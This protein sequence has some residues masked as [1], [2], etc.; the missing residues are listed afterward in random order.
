[1]RL[2]DSPFSKKLSLQIG[3][4]K[5]DFS[6]PKIMGVLNVTPDSFFD[7]GK[8]NSFENAVN[9][10]EK[11]INEGAEF[12]DVGG[13]SSRPGA[14]EVS[15]E[16]E[17]NRTVPVVKA[18]YEKFPAVFISID[19]FRKQVA[20]E[21]IKAGATWVND[22][23]AGKLDAEM[24]P[25]IKAG[26]I[27][28]IAMHM[29]GNPQTMKDKCDYID[30]TN[31]VL[32]ELIS[33]IRELEADHPVIL[34]PGFGFSKTVDQN[35]ELMNN[36]DA[37]AQLDQPFLVGI[38]RKSMIYKFLETTPEDSLNATSVL[39]TIGL[40][41]G[42]SVLRVHDVKEAKEA[43]DLVMKMNKEGHAKK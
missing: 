17:I 42:A 11:M 9:Q 36:L 29:R 18:I 2:K 19:S 40:M 27:P 33:S 21:N 13:Y 41:K 23:S 8:N 35:Y 30:L 20:E 26:K 7:G 28:Y 32:A 4:K 5:I 25:W 34:D 22:I 16:E 6:T 14:D 3:E 10:A 37:F 39:N 15:I 43:V 38:S 31:Q 24:L 12:I 1:M